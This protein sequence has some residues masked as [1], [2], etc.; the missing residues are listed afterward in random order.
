M[1]EQLFS[2]RSSQRC[3][4]IG[5]AAAAGLLVVLVP[6]CGGGGDGAPVQPV[7]PNASETKPVEEAT[8]PA[9]EEL[10]YGIN[11]LHA[12]MGE[13][14]Q[15]LRPHG[16]GWSGAVFSVAPPLPEGLH[17]DAGTGLLSG[18]PVGQ[19]K[20]SSYEITV[21]KGARKS[22]TTLHIQVREP[23]AQVF[24]YATSS[25]EYPSG[26]T[27]APQGPQALK[28]MDWDGG[29]FTVD[30]P[31]P[32]GL[33][34]DSATGVLS[35]TPT[36]G[37]SFG[38]HTVT[39]VKG[40][41]SATGSLYLSVLPAKANAPGA[42]A[43]DQDVPAGTAP[44]PN[45]PK[46]MAPEPNA[47]KGTAPEPN[48]PKGTAPEPTAPERLSYPSAALT[49]TQGV[50]LLP[51]A[52]IWPAIPGT[53]FTVS[54]PLPSG[55]TLD[56]T[57]GVITGVPGRATP[58]CTHTVT[59]TNGTWR[60]SFSLQVVVSSPAPAGF[61]YPSLE[62]GFVKNRT[63]PRLEPLGQHLDGAAFSVSPAM[64]AGMTLNSWTGTIYGT[65]WQVQPATKYTVTATKGE[66]RATAVLTLTVHDEP[67]SSLSYGAFTTTCAVG[68]PLKPL[69]PTHGGGAATTF[70]VTPAL[71]AGLCLDPVTG[72]LSGTPTSAAPQ[73]EFTI[74]ASSISGSTQAVLRLV[75]DPAL[76]A[77]VI[78]LPPFLKQDFW[79]NEASIPDPEPGTQVV[80]TLKGGRNGRHYGPTLR[81]DTGAPGPIKVSVTV[82][83]RR[84]TATAHATAT[85]VPTAK[86]ELVL[87]AAVHPGSPSLQARV[88]Q[89]DGLTYH[90]EVKPED[91]AATLTDGAGTAAIQIA[92]GDQEGSFRVKIEVRN[93]AGGHAEATGT[94]KVQR[95]LWVT[96]DPLDHKKSHTDLTTATVLGDGRVLVVGGCFPMPGHPAGTLAAAALL[97][98][99]AGLWEDAGLPLD[100]ALIEDHTATK[101]PDG[102]VLLVGQT[103]VG[104][105]VKRFDPVTGT[106]LD[107]AP[108]RTPR[109]AHS[110]TL[111]MDGRVLVAGG[112]APGSLDGVKD[113]VKETE[114]YLPDQ[115]VWQEAAPMLGVHG[116]HTATLLVDGEVL[117]AGGAPDGRSAEYYQPFWDKWTAAGRM[118]VTRVNHTA[119]RLPNGKVLVAGGDS[120]LS[121][122][123]AEVYDPKTE[124]WN[125]IGAPKGGF[126]RHSATLLDNGQV[127]VAGGAEDFNKRATKVSACFDPAT[128]AWTDAGPLCGHRA[129]HGAVLL[130]DGRVLLVLGMVNEH[131]TEF[132]LPKTMTPPPA[133]TSH[134]TGLDAGLKADYALLGVDPLVAPSP[135]EVQKA[136]R[137]LARIWHPDKHPAADKPMAAVKFNELR[138]AMERI[139]KALE[140]TAP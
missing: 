105:A 92:I 126:F 9:P 26:Q 102:S 50:A 20:A 122:S 111:L 44:V 140:L 113:G 47:P 86:V 106:W 23:A 13:P 83:N 65:P 127:L 32:S 75:V 3:W 114:L 131:A 12:V 52:P 85:V 101:L 128:Q 49:L 124:S 87:P 29:T 123:K 133:G 46:G 82:T 62:H 125:P 76:E 15:E 78:T 67:P 22:A 16:N 119:T 69:T 107:A 77:P 55:L 68:M 56:A 58:G 79:N 24:W 17:L 74:T 91:T 30:P 129:G 138:E 112:L 11:S 80:W 40:Q 36:G 27:I 35:G 4:S 18:T 103:K 42:P 21:Q 33:V 43:V 73:A 81:F 72:V 10:T 96:R 104:A 61:T 94:V 31:L 132:Y 120:W 5:R 38:V 118:N 116:G 51:Q 14:L 135:A 28:G 110:A 37:A 95:G 63:I 66:A 70:G 48:A 88:A 39:F 41:T 60:R 90:W 2:P 108:L 71:P 93:L 99:D 98:P 115:N 8:D 19:A 121:H 54:P 136:Y 1:S 139:L 53:S 6:G 117:V 34:L 45:P 59:A 130:P 89:V 25:P 109:H 100:E 134:G 97:N 84:G 64:P 57:T 137:K 7:P